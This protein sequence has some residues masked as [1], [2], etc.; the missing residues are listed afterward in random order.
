MSISPQDAQQKML[1]GQV[2]FI[3]LTEA[4]GRIA[5][6]LALV[7]PPGIGVIFPGERYDDNAQPMMDYFQLFE[8]TL[9]ILLYTSRYLGEIS[10]ACL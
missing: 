5:A 8:E 4:K 1:N 9:I 7:Y 3:P 10:N 6:T 2:D